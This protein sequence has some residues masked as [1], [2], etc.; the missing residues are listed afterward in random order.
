MAEKKQPP[1]FV[2]QVVIY[3]LGLTLNYGIGF[4]LLPVYTHMMPAEQYGILEIL[5]RTIEIVSIL[6]LTQF[7]IAF[8]RFY[9]D[10]PDE[11]Y[12]RVVVSTCI[13][14]VAGVSLVMGGSLALLREPLSQLLFQSSGYSAYFGLAALKYVA[15]MAY[16]IPLVYFQAREEPGK[17]ITISAAHFAINFGLIIFLLY[18]KEDKVAAA[19]LGTTIA[20]TLFLIT[21]G[22]WVFLRSARRLSWP[23]TVELIKFSWSFTFLGIYA[24]VITSGDRFFLNEYCNKTA[25]GIYAAGYK[26]GMTLNYFIF[27]PILRA[28]NAKMV[29]VM[30]TAEGESK[31]S[32]LTCYSLLIYCTVGLAVSV[33]SREIAGIALDSQYFASHR[34]IPIILLAYAFSGMAV[35][36]DTGIY[37]SKKTYLKTWHTVSAVVCIGLYFLLIPSYCMTGAAWA[38]VGAYMVLAVIAWIIGQYAMPIKYDLKRMILILLPAIALYAVNVEMEDR[39]AEV[40]SLPLLLAAK[41]GLVLL[42]IGTMFLLRVVA[43]EDAQRVREIVNDVRGR[44]SG[45]SRDLSAGPPLD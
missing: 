14:L 44:F 5:N 24:F 16:V 31:V 6:L 25:T 9:R 39:F 18:V 3:G 17:Y 1:G 29:D 41:A 42:Y 20:H 2:R 35:L 4:I 38:T 12:R 36:F 45:R 22:V 27:A 7:A 21:V 40:W 10:K 34:I 13:Y 28:W 11:D 23:L 8:I 30:R 37:I 43:S 19:L 15:G 32:R 33:Y 26:I